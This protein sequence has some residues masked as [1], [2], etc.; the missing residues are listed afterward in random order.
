MAVAMILKGRFFFSGHFDVT[1]QLSHWWLS[2]WDRSTLAGPPKGWAQSSLR[3][4][5]SCLIC[6]TAIAAPKTFQHFQQVISSP[7]EW[8]RTQLPRNPQATGTT[9]FLLSDCTHL[10]LNWWETSAL[11]F[12]MNPLLFPQLSH[13]RTVGSIKVS[14]VLVCSLSLCFCIEEKD[15]TSFPEL[16][17]R[18]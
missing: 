13:G 4:Q 14:L 2:F 10:G 18:L 12:Y 9:P 8:R 3:N 15:H 5:V 1:R 6:F 17:N 7:R 16:K 11:L